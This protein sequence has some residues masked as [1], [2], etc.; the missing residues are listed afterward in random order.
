MALKATIEGVDRLLANLQARQAKAAGRPVVRVSY[1][2]S[3]AVKVHE[4]LDVFHPTGQAKYLEQPTRTMQRQMGQIVANSMRAGS[5]VLQ[6]EMAAAQE[7][8]KAS[9]ALVP[10]DTGRLRASGRVTVEA[11]A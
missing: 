10:V 1:S 6:A 3:Y 4:R 5:T 11:S 2:T 7:L 9:Q 8:L